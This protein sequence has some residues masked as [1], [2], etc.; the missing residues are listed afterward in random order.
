MEKQYQD[1]VIYQ[2]CFYVPE[3]HTESVKNA[4]FE[5]GAGQLGSYSQCAWQ[6][7]GQGQFK[8]SD[9]S[10]PF[11]GKADKIETVKEHK[12]ELLCEGKYLQSTIQALKTSHP[13]EMP[14]FFITESVSVK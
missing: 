8:P 9:E 1:S 6:T 12:V 11:L 3:T 5:A 2:I 7:L 4:L 13:Y 14:A 10:N